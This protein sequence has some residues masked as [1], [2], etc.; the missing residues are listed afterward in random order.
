MPARR[1]VLEESWPETASRRP[2][3][4]T[5]SITPSATWTSSPCTVT[6][7][8]CPHRCWWSFQSCG[9]RAVTGAAGR[10]QVRVQRP[11]AGAELPTGGARP[12]VRSPGASA[13][14]A[15]ARAPCASLPPA[16]EG[17]AHRPA[18]GGGAFGPRGPERRPGSPHSDVCEPGGRGSEAEVGGFSAGAHA[19]VRLVPRRG[20]CGRQP[21]MTPSHH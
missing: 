4:A 11:E 9:E 5:F 21:A 18:P 1:E 19:G 14:E 8:A 12:G 10:S 16:S 7:A 6:D 20:A 17:P 13:T 3:T 2:H 15:A